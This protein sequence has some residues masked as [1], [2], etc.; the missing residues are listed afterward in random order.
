ME[1]EN[2]AINTNTSDL[3]DIEKNDPAELDNNKSKLQTRLEISGL[4]TNHNGQAIADVLI[5]GRGGF[6]PTKTDSNGQYRIV[7]QK[8]G[9]VDLLLNFS[10]KGYEKQKIIIVKQEF[11][12]SPILN[13]D[14]TLA[15]K[16]DTQSTTSLSGKVSNL[17]G[18]GLANQRIRLITLGD[19]SDNEVRYI[20]VALTD[21]NGDFT[22]SDVSINTH[23][24]LVV[25]AAEYARYTVEDLLV[26]N[27]TPDLDIILEDLKLTIKS[28]QVIDREGV[29]LP[30]LKISA[31]NIATGVSKNLVTNDLG[32]FQLENFPEGEVSFNIKSPADIKISGMKLSEMDSQT[33]T[34]TIDSGNHFLSGS[35]SD[36]DGKTIENAT[37]TMQ[38]TYSKNNVDSL[39]LRSVTTDSTGTFSFE[40]FGADEHII[41]IISKGFK[42]QMIVHQPHSSD[43]NLN[44]ILERR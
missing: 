36:S 9:F 31:N 37:V 18:E 28:G 39:S 24:K 12:R 43:T 21:N 20:E 10:L 17:I 6:P 8:G 15:D 42:R 41:I 3:P 13:W 30:N 35:V 19:Y 7:I 14:V 26:T 25:L 40:N 16:V 33:I 4:I 38:S 29:P 5:Y 32:G 22:L 23:Y 27:D 34:L 11:E 2:S 44:I 1:A